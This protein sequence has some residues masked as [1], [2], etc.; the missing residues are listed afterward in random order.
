[1]TTAEPYFHRCPP[2]PDCPYCS[3]LETA[4][5]AGGLDWSFLDGAYCISLQSRPDRAERVAREF[6]RVGLCQQVVF[7]RPVK[8]PTSSK[9]GIWASH[10]AVAGE[11]RDHGQ[12]RVL[13]LED[14][15]VF[16]RSL[17]P[18]S[19]AKIR[20][21]LE[22]LARSDA[23]R[24][25]IVGTGAVAIQAVPAPCAVR[26]YES[27]EVWGRSTFKAASLV[28]HVADLGF[29]ATVAGDLDES[30]AAAD[31]ISCSTGSTEPLVKGALLRP[32]THVDLIG[33]LT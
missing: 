15:V 12:K 29:D 31:V 33:S 5:G 18:R 2:D 27:I 6:H 20:R 23:S 1:M 28:E 8:H 11:A 19:M 30:V 32:G 16:S 10:R 9:K 21:S 13:I 22:R 7:Y 25:L 4:R 26:S 14:D 3:D 24:L 17:G